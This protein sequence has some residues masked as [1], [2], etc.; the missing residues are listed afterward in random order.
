MLKEFIPRNS[1]NCQHALDTYRGLSST[2]NRNALIILLG[3]SLYYY[4]LCT[5]KS[6]LAPS[7]M[8]Q[9]REGRALLGTTNTVN[10]TV[11]FGPTVPTGQSGPPPEVVPNI[12]V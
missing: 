6:A 12:P 7:W 8:N 2:H 1:K 9:A 4:S 3:Q 5:D 11:N 10:G